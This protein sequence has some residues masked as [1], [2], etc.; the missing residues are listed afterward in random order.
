MKSLKKLHRRKKK[1]SKFRKKKLG[2]SDRSTTP[3]PKSGDIP[4][5]NLPTTAPPAPKPNPRLPGRPSTPKI[6]EKK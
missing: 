5:P 1:T 3:P 4:I 2:G 6:G